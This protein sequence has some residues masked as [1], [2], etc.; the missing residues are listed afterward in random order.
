M[1]SNYSAKSME[2]RN[3]PVEVK[4]SG[5]GKAF[6][7]ASFIL[8]IP[9]IWFISRRNNIIK[10]NN[11]VIQVHQSIDIILTKRANALALVFQSTKKYFKHEKE[12]LEN[13]TKARGNANRPTSSDKGMDISTKDAV[14][15]AGTRAFNM[16][17][18]KYPEL[19]AMKAVKEFDSVVLDIEEEISNTRRFY[20]SAVLKYNTA[21]QQYPSNVPASTIEDPISGGPLMTYPMF[22]AQDEDRK[23]P[24]KGTDGKMLS[25]D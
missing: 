4:A 12:L 19:K 10:M 17:R 22:E 13:V 1:A 8:V 5:G 24:L 9:A 14:L 6:F 18:E 25:F 3:K 21:L 15:V 2:K 23:N 16:V 7:Y 20:N 11:K